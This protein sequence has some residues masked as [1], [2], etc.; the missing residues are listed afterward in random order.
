MKNILP[1]IIV[2][3]SLLL[4]GGG[5]QFIQENPGL[6]KSV[7]KTVM[8]LGLRMAVAKLVGDKPGIIPWLQVVA[9]TLQ[10]PV[11]S[12]SPKALRAHLN[13]VITNKVED[14]IY[15]QS[16]YDLVDIIAGF[17]SDVYEKHQHTLAKWTYLEIIQSFGDAIESS[18]GPATVQSV[19]YELETDRAIIRIQ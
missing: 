10:E 8:N 4:G 11:E 18:I 5:C 1:A 7:G 19:G 2:S 17:Y 6:V 12:A 3:V 15:R 14:T 16:L 13:S 9:D